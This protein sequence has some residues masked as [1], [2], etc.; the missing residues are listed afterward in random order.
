[1]NA[2]YFAPASAGGSGFRLAGIPSYQ[3]K[4]HW[5]TA[6]ELWLTVP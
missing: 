5:Y 6:R 4:Y 3:P 2:T 1:M